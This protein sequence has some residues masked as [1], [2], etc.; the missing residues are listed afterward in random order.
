MKMMLDHPAYEEDTIVI[1]I[2]ADKEYVNNTIITLENLVV[3]N[4]IEPEKK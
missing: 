3:N 2:Y 4:R 1:A